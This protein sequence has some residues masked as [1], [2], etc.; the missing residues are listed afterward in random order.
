MGDEKNTERTEQNAE[1]IKPE[2]NGT[3]EPSER[4]STERRKEDRRKGD[5]R[6]GIDRR[7]EARRTEDEAPPSMQSAYKASVLH[8]IVGKLIDIFIFAAF[9]K[10]FEEVGGGMG[11]LYLL[12]AD[13]IKNGASVGKHLVRLRVIKSNGKVAGL[14]ESIMRNLTIAFAMGVLVIPA[15]G[16][17]LFFT[18]GALV[19][20]VETYFVIHDPQGTRIG[21]LIAQT[22]V[23]ELP[24]NED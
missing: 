17:I 8:R 24:Q 20:A 7:E 3:E 4:R 12:I 21:D 14:S 19:L 1:E 10:T 15:I 6:S 9:Y 13:G 5:R 22:S 2:Q 11:I 23:E 16:W 18:I